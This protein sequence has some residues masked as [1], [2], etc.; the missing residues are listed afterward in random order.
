MT[1]IY[2]VILKRHT[3]SSRSDVCVFYDEDKEKVIKAMADYDKKNGFSIYE[4]DGRF[5]IA[6]IILRERQSTGEVISETPYRNLF[7][8]YGN[9]IKENKL[10]QSQ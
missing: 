9:R 3:G 5:S 2:D 7:D 4:K 6:N 8:V 10:G 1:V